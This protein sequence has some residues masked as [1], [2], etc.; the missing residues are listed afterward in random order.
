MR[1][2]PILTTVGF[3]ADDHHVFALGQGGKYL[4]A[5]LKPE[6][7]DGCEDDATRGAAVQQATQLFAAVGLH[8]HL[9]YQ[10]GVLAEGLEQLA[11]EVVAV[12]DHNDGRVLQFRRHE[13]HRGTAD[14]L[15]GFTRALGMPHHAT[16]A[17]AARGRSADNALG[18]GQHRVELVV[19]RDF[20]D[21]DA[22]VL[23]QNEVAQILQKKV[24]SEHPADEGLQLLLLA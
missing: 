13:Q 10:V 1:G 19:T 21:Q 18:H 16:L 5:S 12:R 22:L 8:R 23:E 11:I 17:V 20:L 14:H 4:L 2:E 7:L 3:V 6:L 24:F 9:P 15:D